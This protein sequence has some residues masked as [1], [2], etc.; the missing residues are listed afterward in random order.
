MTKL[1][2]LLPYISLLEKYGPQI[3]ALIP[4]WLDPSKSLADKFKDTDD[5]FTQ[6]FPVNSPFESVELMLFSTLV[7]LF[8]K[9]STA[10]A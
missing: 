8:H 3:A 7:S 10:T 1:T 2:D 5:Q 9:Q 4:T 6:D